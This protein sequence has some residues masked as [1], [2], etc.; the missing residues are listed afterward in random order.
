MV[1]VMVM[2]MWLVTIIQNED[3]FNNSA[4][5]ADDC[6][7]DGCRNDDKDR[8]LLEFYILATSTVLSV[9]ALTCDNV[10]PS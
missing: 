10:H 5:D 4:I 6:N 8:W 9:L 2:G 7:N 1:A 3:N